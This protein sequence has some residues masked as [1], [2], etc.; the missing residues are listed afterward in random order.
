MSPHGASPSYPREAWSAADIIRLREMWAEGL[1]TRTL[2]K[3][4]GRSERAIGHKVAELGLKYGVPQGHITLHQASLDYGIDRQKLL[5]LLAE[6]GVAVRLLRRPLNGSLVQSSRRVRFVDIGDMEEIADAEALRDREDLCKM[7]LHRYA[8]SVGIAPIRIYR[9][10]H[11]MGL[12]MRTKF[13][14]DVLAW[15]FAACMIVD[16]AKEI[17]AERRGKR[18]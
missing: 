15:I 17:S 2:T 3:R 7:S 11:M 14:N 4:L 8:L 1:S 16:Y 13:N 12:P 18:A 9:M 10:A 6:N 5:K